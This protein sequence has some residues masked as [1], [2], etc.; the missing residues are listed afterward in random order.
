MLLHQ[1]C[2]KQHNQ[3]FHKKGA[4]YDITNQI[5][6]VGG[7]LH[8][9]FYGFSRDYYKKYQNDGKLFDVEETNPGM[10]MKGFK[11]NIDP[12]VVDKLSLV[13]Y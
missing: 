5:H 13:L 8:G 6:P 10:E 3:S 11:K 4:S 12:W 1:W 9:W 2:L 7:G